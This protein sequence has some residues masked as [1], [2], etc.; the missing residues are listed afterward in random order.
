MDAASS[1]LL[2]MPLVDAV[3]VLIDRM[4][5]SPFTRVSRNA[6]YRELQ[7]KTGY[8]PEHLRKQILGE[9]TVQPHVL[10]ELAR[11]FGVKPT[12]FREYRRWMLEV[13][14]NGDPDL[15][16]EMWEMLQAEDRLARQPVPERARRRAQHLQ[17]A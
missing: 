11:L 8:K 3:E 7:D 15:A 9:R 4:K 17:P 10:V 13:S 16:D 2:R 5:P 14:L 6:I 1:D 12:V